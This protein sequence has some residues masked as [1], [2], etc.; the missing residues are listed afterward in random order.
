[1]TLNYLQKIARGLPFTIIPV[2]LSRLGCRVSRDLL[3][4]PETPADSHSIPYPHRGDKHIVNHPIPVK[5]TLSI[6]GR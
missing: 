5:T 3:Y 4:L 1:M 2:S 6:L